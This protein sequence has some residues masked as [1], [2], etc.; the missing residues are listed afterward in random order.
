[1]PIKSSLFF[2]ASYRKFNED[3]VSVLFVEFIE[4]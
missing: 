4:V 2:S 1:M 3:G